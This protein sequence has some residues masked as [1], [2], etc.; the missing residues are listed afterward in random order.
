MGVESIMAS[1]RKTPAWL[2]AVKVALAIPLAFVRART[3]FGWAASAP[4]K[5]PL[6]GSGL[7]ST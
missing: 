1:T 7:W 6:N 4:L 5:V 2:P 3:T